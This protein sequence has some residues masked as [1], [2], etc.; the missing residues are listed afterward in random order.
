MFSGVEGK[1]SADQGPAVM[2]RT[3]SAS[4]VK[5]VALAILL[6][7]AVGLGLLLFLGVPTAQPPASTASAVAV[8]EASAGNASREKRSDSAQQ[9]SAGEAR[10]PLAD[11]VRVWES[12]QSG[13]GAGTGPTGDSP[14]G[15]CPFDGPAD[16]A[17]QGRIDELVFG[18]L[19]QLGIEPAHVCSDGVFLRRAYLDVIGTLPSADAVR[20]FLQ[21]QAP[22]KRAALI[23]RLLARPEFADY[24]AMKWCDLLR[25]KA[26]FPIN[27]WPN[28]AQAYHRWLRASI[29]ANLPYDRFVR[30]LLTASGSNFRVPQ[31]NFYRA[32]QNR[33]PAT[34]AKAVALAFMG[35]RAEKWPA[36]QLAGMAAFFS[37]IG[38]KPT[39]EWKEEIVIFDPSKGKAKP[40]EPPRP[41]PVFPDGSPAK[42]EPDQDPREV[43]ADWLIAP[44]NPW[45][46]RQIV[47][48]V[49]FWLLGRGIVH[50]PDDIR[51]GNVPQN[52]ELLN[53]LGAELIAARYD[54][55]H[56][57]RLILNSKTYQ[58][59]CVPRS[60]D[61]Q[62]AAHFAHYS[63]RRLEAEVLIDA[64]CQITGTTESYSSMIPEP[65][66][67]I[68]EDRRSIALPDGSKTST[69]LEMFGRPPRA[70]GLESERNNRTTAAQRLHL[71]NSSHVRRKIQEGPA[72]Q[73]LLRSGG[74]GSQ[75]AE[76]LYV[77]I[78]SRFPTTEEKAIAEEY[79]RSGSGGQTIAWALINSDEF[80]HRH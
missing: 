56:I 68:P 51:P 31:V 73:R 7:L 8:R 46:A 29:R 17:P 9:P 38:Y 74:D 63:L 76:A 57:Y 13:S 78:L 20:S 4:P 16:M 70:T 45:F 50:E 27:L 14:N 72:L 40:G 10:D 22:D 37:Q 15:Q 47:N 77:A 67:F 75:V 79:C 33:E 1:G 24:W 62:A 58:L 2:P 66:T 54:L 71:L 49:W 69:F 19:K 53:W 59:S 5:T 48:R 80:L 6:A 21:D 43:F 26:E 30:E 11:A 39:G 44:E 65:F 34:I 64:L 3:S 60:Q 36:E 61:P 25:V 28:A 32:L 23:D 41:A 18:K 55:K 12:K 35:S 52:P 42:I